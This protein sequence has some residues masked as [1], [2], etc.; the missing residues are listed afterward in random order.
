M[1]INKPSVNINNLQLYVDSEYNNNIP[2][3]QTY[4]SQLSDFDTCFKNKHTFNLMNNYEECCYKSNFSCSFPISYEISR[5]QSTSIFIPTIK[6]L[7]KSM[8]KNQKIYLFWS[9]FYLIIA[10][11][12]WNFKYAPIFSSALGSI[13]MYDAISMFLKRIEV[14]GKF[15]IAVFLLYMAM[16]SLKSIMEEI[17]INSLSKDQP[18]KKMESNQI[19]WSFPPV[20]IIISI[21]ITIVSALYFNNH[22][23]LAKGIFSS[24]GMFSTL[25]NP[26]H[27]KSL[28]PLFV[29]LFI[30]LASPSTINTLDKYLTLLFEIPIC[31]LGYIVI[32]K[33]GRILILSFPGDNVQNCIKEL[34]KVSLIHSVKLVNIWQPYFSFYMAN[35]N[36]TTKDDENMNLKIREFINNVLYQKFGKTIEDNEIENMWEIN[37]SIEKI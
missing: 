32:K 3:T 13:I 1:D 14:L 37:I 2:I 5:F 30:T 35:F 20:I 24:S 18:L 31:I 15:S 9:C 23:Q 33:L 4:L 26:F 19:L 28:L 36:I 21:V 10:F 29:Y 11:L 25:L 27:L 12:I 7:L 22:S 8:T 34:E 6:D 16:N 17:I